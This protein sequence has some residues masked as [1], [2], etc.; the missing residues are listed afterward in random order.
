VIVYLLA[1]L[2]ADYDPFVT[3]LT[4]RSDH[5]TLD[6]V[7]AHLM[8]FEARQLKHEADQQPA[9]ASSA[10]YTGRGGCGR[11]RRGR[12]AP[13]P[14]RQWQNRGRGTSPRPI[15]QICGKEGHTAIHCWYRN[16]DSYNQEHPSAAMVTTTSYKVDPNWCETLFGFGN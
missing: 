16:D 8:A 2:P 15:C 10:N 1:G 4:T 12:G 13:P 6:D 5:L 9:Y 11:G 7:Y 14:Q 3:S